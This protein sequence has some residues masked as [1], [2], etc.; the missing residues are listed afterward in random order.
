MEKGVSPESRVKVEAGPVSKALVQQGWR[1][2]LVKTHNEAGITPVLQAVSPNAA[3]VYRRS[4]GSKAPSIDITPADV[5]QRWLDIE[6][7]IEAQTL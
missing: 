1:T 5:V 2:F 4:R 3:P 6:K 7:I